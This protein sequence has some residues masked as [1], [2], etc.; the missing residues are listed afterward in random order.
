MTRLLVLCL[1]LVGLNSQ[2]E[3][4]DEGNLELTITPGT[5]LKLDLSAGDYRIAAGQLDRLLITAK[6]KNPSDRAKVHFRVNA[7]TRAAT[8]KVEGPRDFAATIE[9]PRNV[10]LSVRLTAG[11]LLLDHIQ[12][13]KDI[14]SMAGELEIN[15]GKPNDYRSVH[16]SV[17]AGEIDASAFQSQKGGLFRTFDSTGPGM[18]RLRV[19]VG[20]GQIR[21]FTAEDE[22]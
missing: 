3:V 21:L 9:I 16:A 17:N 8:V 6:P 1:C 4:R 19:H 13:D 14:E 22:I 7:S 5:A 2:P 11:K 10:N 12:G 20:A 15:V 18:Y